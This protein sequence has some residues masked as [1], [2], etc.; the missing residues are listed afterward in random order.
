MA[1][2]KQKILAAFRLLFRPVA[3]ILL[4]AGI[5]W[6]DVAEIGKATYV[7]AAS[8]E[9]GIRGR[10]TN[11]TRVAILTGFSR[12]EVARLR[13][14]LASDE[15][16]EIDSMNHATRVL[17]GW[18][19]DAAYIDGNGEPLPLRVD[20]DDVSFTALCKRYASDVH[21]STMLKELKHV[22]AITELAD[23]RVTAKTRY[24]MP[25]Q[26]D[27]VRVLSSGSVLEDLGETVAYNLYR[28][29][30]DLPRFERRATNTRIPR[31][32]V[33]DFQAFLEDEGQAFL[34]RVDQWLTDHELDQ[35]SAEQ[36]I[37]LGLGAYWI[38]Q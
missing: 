26:P 7:V 32:A 14:L 35:T 8:S 17:T 34:E 11:A 13:A 18:H 15:S 25:Q 16:Q 3:K 33:P 27:P 5:P 12:K 20:S 30:T 28:T 21:V 37:R 24:Y 6:K 22:G 2:S 36:G 19:T 1:F 9:F 10:P 29:D 4:F 23:G 31:S 38:Q